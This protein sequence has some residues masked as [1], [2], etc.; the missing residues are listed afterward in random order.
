M[1][2]LKHAPK[3]LV[4]DRLYKIACEELSQLKYLPNDLV[5]GFLGCVYAR[6]GVPR[7]NP[8]P[9]TAAEIVQDAIYDSFYGGVE[10]EF[11][12]E[13]EY[14]KFNKALDD[15]KEVMFVPIK[16]AIIQKDSWGHPYSQILRRSPYKDKT[17]P[18]LCSKEKFF[19]SY[20]KY[21]DMTKVDE[22][23][24]YINSEL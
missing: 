4:P 16:A 14:N 5:I 3:I 2:I 13:L 22:N 23:Y 17:I 8:V 1:I 7:I 24:N 9:I 11:E 18:Y 6:A 21:I 10:P 19:S 20:L 12:T 15:L